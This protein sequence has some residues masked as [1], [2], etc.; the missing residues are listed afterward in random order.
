MCLWLIVN[1]SADVKDFPAGANGWQQGMTLVGRPNPQQAQIDSRKYPITSLSKP[2][3]N[4]YIGPDT[5]RP[6]ATS[7]LGM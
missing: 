1:W 7:T 3:S 2:F 5:R 4:T 6:N